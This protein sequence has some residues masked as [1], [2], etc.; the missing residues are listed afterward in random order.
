MPPTFPEISGPLPAHTGI[1]REE[2]VAL[3]QLLGYGR[4]TEASLRLSVPEI[5]TRLPGSSMKDVLFVGLDIDTFQGYEV[6]IPDQQMHV[7]ISILDTRHLKD[8]LT[9]PTREEELSAAIDSYQFTVGT[10]RDYCRRAH[11]RFLFGQ[12]KPVESTSEL[13]P[14]LEPLVEGRDTVLVCHSTVSDLKMLRNLDIDLRPLY[15]MDT[16]KVA[17]YPLQLHYRYSLEKLLDTLEI[18]YTSLHAA[19]NDARFCLQALL[20][21]AVKDAEKDQPGAADESLFRLL[22][23]IAQVPRPRTRKEIED[24]L[25]VV[26]RATKKEKQAA[27]KAARKERRRLRLESRKDAKAAKLDAEEPDDPG[28]LGFPLLCLGD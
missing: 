24:T 12:S 25:V 3:R 19:G 17:Q 21:L 2:T 18:P 10:Y 20:M 26:G 1:L 16:N 23:G 28:V 9:S 4:P 6:I 13:K 11:N 22:G 7:G 14:E 5:G 8:L 15:S 27:N